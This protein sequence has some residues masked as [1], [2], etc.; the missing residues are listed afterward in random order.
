MRLYGVSA[1]Q[2]E[3]IVASPIARGQDKNG[4]PRY[5]GYVG[6]QLIRVMVALDEPDLILSV[7]PRRHL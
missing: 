5:F 2:A 1:E 3:A 7:H 6:D 4:K